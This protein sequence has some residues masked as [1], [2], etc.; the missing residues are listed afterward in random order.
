[1]DTLVTK[2]NETEFRPLTAK[3]RCDRCGAQA[4]VHARLRQ[5]AELFLCAHHGREHMPAL[6]A[7]KFNVKDWSDQ[8]LAEESGQRKQGS[9]N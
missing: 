5:R 1:M 2:D 9:E 4:W 3:D 6:I 7:Q 8:L